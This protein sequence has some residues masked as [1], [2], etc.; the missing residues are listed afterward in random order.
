MA[1]TGKTLDVICV[2]E[3][4]VDFLPERPGQPVHAVERWLRHPGGAPSNVAIGTARLGATSALIGVVGD[5]EFGQFL[6]ERLA[7]EGVDVTHVRQT[8]NGPTGLAFISVTATGERSFCFHRENSAELHLEPR[9]ISAEALAR[10]GI[11]HF[12]TN[13]LVR[14]PSRQAAQLAM[15][16]AREAGACISCDP[17]LRLKLWRDPHELRLLLDGLLPG[18]HVVKLSHDEIAFALDT[19]D[20]DLA[21]RRLAQ[22]GVRLPIV[23]LAERGAAFWWEGAVHRVPAPVVEVV[24]CTGAGDGFTSGLLYGLARSG[25]LDALDLTRLREIIT[26]ACEIG[27][28]VVTGLGAVASLPRRSELEQLMPGWMNISEGN[29]ADNADPDPRR[30]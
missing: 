29:S 23:T 16:L 9:D 15:R 17:N 5:D 25:G 7:A 1:A 22:S 6:R 19:T 3:A 12:G 2:G 24:D 11:V 30:A 18:C 21:L 27:S 10:A 8:P 26:F 13:S 20:V 4:L 14:A 28:R